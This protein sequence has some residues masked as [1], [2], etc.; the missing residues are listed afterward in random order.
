M[1]RNERGYKYCGGD[2]VRYRP[3]GGYR[4]ALECIGLEADAVQ[5]NNFYNVLSSYLNRYNAI[6]L[7][8]DINNN[9]NVRFP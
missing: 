8:V 6:P 4:G 1:Y 3:D 7:N 9:T 2:G 5:L